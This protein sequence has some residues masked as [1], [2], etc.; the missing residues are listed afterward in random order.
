MTAPPDGN[1]APAGFPGPA[2]AIP[3]DALSFDELLAIAESRRVAG[4]RFVPAESV[5]RD[6]ARRVR[7]DPHCK[8]RMCQETDKEGV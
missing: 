3:E 4:R 6:N 8:C 1:N 7:L 5:P 2:R